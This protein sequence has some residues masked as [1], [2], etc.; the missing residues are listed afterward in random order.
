[1]PN[2]T[3]NTTLFSQTT[4]QKIR[5][6]L[7]RHTKCVGLDSQFLVWVRHPKRLGH[8]LLMHCLSPNS[9]PI[10]LLVSNT[11]K[12]RKEK[13]SCRASRG[14]MMIYGSLDPQVITYLAAEI[15]IK[16]RGR[17]CWN[18]DGVGWNS[19]APCLWIWKLQKK[20]PCLNPN[21]GDPW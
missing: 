4:L 8:S 2:T 21:L 19:L 9:D 6:L 3:G 5:F 12:F 16:H 20:V 11:K 17:D 13:R 7:P 14:S 18:N 15:L 10:T 1:M